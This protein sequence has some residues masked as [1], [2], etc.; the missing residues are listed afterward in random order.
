MAQLKAKGTRTAP[1]PLSM[2]ESTPT[3]RR[4]RLRDTVTSWRV[5]KIIGASDIKVKYKQSVLGPIWLLLQP[6]GILVALA[7]AF[8]GVTQVDTRGVPYPL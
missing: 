2:R 1:S 3:S 4:V 8:A 7:I 6:M 5:A